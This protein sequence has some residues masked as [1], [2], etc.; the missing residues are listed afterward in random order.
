MATVSAVALW[1][2]RQRGDDA[3]GLVSSHEDL[4]AAM[5]VVLASNAASA[6]APVSRLSGL[7]SPECVSNRDLYV[8]LVDTGQRMNDAGC[9][10]AEFLHAWWSVGRTVADQ[11]RFEPD[12]VAAIITAAAMLT[13]TP[14]PLGWRTARYRFVGPAGNLRR[15]GHDHLVP[16][17][18]PGRPRRCRTA[19]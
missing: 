13:P 3:D 6:P 16:A 10:L 18:R 9:G 1:E 17:R 15:L 7:P 14:L 11:D 19:P 2:V 12:M 8:R 4:I 5:A